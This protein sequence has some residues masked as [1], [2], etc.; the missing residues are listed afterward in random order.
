MDG[1]GRTASGT[2]VES[3]AW[4]SCRKARRVGAMDCAQFGVSPRMDCR[5]TPESLRG[6][7]G[8]EPGERRFGVA[9][10]LVTFSLATQREVTR[11]LEAS[12]KRQGCRATQERALS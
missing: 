7:G 1:G 6:L 2:A 11:S 10:L 3:N 4:S 5:Q 12:E 9:F 8:Q